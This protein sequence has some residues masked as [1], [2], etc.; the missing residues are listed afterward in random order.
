M[1]PSELSDIQAKRRVSSQGLGQIAGKALKG[2]VPG[3]KSPDRYFYYPREGSGQIAEAYCHRAVKNDVELRLDTKVTRLFRQGNRIDR[4]ELESTDGKTQI[5]PD[6]I[7]SS[8]PITDMVT[9][10]NPSLDNGIAEAAASLVFR[11]MVLVYLE[12]ETGQ[13]TPWDAHYFPEIGVPF[14]RMSEPKNYSEATEPADRTI[15]CVE[16]PCDV[17]DTIWNANADDLEK[18][19]TEALNRLGFPEYPVLDV[20]LVKLPQAYPVYYTGYQKHLDTLLKQ[21][22]LWE[23]FVT[24]GRQGLFWYANMHHVMDAGHRLSTCFQSGRFDHA[25]WQNIRNQMET[26]TV[27]D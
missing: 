3:A 7:F 26:I 16:I 27:A 6:W 15:L 20:S 14:S 24:F 18:P 19:I 10:C 21:L 1:Q 2:I 13:F 22:K 5:S 8:L 11:G 25:V 4:I 17:G 12:L 9:M 23:N